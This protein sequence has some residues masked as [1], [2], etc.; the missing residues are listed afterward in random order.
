MFSIG[1]TSGVVYT[2]GK[3]FDREVTDECDVFVE[4]KV[5]GGAKVAHATVKVT[6]EDVN[7]NKPIFVNQPYHAIVKTSA[8]KGDV[9][10]KVLAV[11]RDINENGDIRF[12]LLRGNGAVK[13]LH[14]LDNE[15]YP[16]FDFTVRI[17]DKRSPKL[18][19]E[20][21][22][23]VII[24]VEDV[25]DCPPK[26]SQQVYNTTLFVPTYPG[27]F[28]TELKAVDA[29]STNSQLRYCIVAGSIDNKF[30]IGS[31]SGIVTV[32]NGLLKP[33]YQL[34][35][36]VT[37]GHYASAT[38]LTIYVDTVKND[39]LSLHKRFIQQLSLKIQ[40]RC[41]RLLFCKS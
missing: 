20:N 24:R 31:K 32:A 18:I 5:E 19:S 21:Y 17:S 4:A 27:V 37:D 41:K 8:Q 28:V 12:E 33:F 2:S 22:T 38:V 11:D 36:T 40:Q 30:S 13:I 9:I 29:D 34:D 6:I 25:N 16:E 7:D 3:P 1:R 23:H 10:G 15:S 26:F 39:S 14:L 35:I